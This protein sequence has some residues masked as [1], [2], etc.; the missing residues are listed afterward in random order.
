MVCFIK[1]ALPN[2]DFSVLIS[3][4]TECYPN[5][6]DS[7]NPINFINTQAVASRYHQLT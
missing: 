3:G 7:R 6:T 4:Q 5:Q 2:V 1:H